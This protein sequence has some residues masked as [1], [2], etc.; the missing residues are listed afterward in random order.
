MII[1][2]HNKD[3]LDIQF[4]QPKE[5]STDL[6]TKVAEVD[7][8]DLDTAFRDTN[9]IDKDWIENEGVTSLVSRP[10][11]TS[12][13]DVME[14]DGKFFMVASCGFKEMKIV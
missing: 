1:V 9:H 2:Y 8:N 11:S 7:S 10:R 14:I 6:L 4:D 3:F 5:I 13:G 12:V